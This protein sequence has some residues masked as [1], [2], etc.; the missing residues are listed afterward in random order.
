MNEWG[1]NRSPRGPGLTRAMTDECAKHRGQENWG[2][3][4]S[5]PE[6]TALDTVQGPHP[7][8]ESQHFL[9]VGSASPWLRDSEHIT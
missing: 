1:H 3:C 9:G 4:L 7:N 2:S 6:G 8:P 5:P